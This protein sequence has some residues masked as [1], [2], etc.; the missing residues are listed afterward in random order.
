M[1]VTRPNGPVDMR[2]TVLR[3]AEI[4]HSLRQVQKV[5]GTVALQQQKSWPRWDV[6]DTNQLHGNDHSVDSTRHSV[7]SMP[8]WGETQDYSTQRTRYAVTPTSSKT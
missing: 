3:S 4:P 5:C 7:R 2:A 8:H 6:M 1:L